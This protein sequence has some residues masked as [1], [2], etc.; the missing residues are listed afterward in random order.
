MEQRTWIQVTL[1]RR[2]ETKVFVDP[3][4][5]AEWAANLLNVVKVEM[6]IN[7][8]ALDPIVVQALLNGDY[9]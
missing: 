8:Q 1:P 9:Q 3:Y 2:V 6:Q 5:A 4:A 7:G